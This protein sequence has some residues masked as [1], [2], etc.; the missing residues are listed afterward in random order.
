MQSY[1]PPP[2][3]ERLLLH[4]IADGVLDPHLD[5]LAQAIHARRR[6]LLHTLATQTAL[7]QLCAGDQV[8]IDNTVRPLYLRGLRGRVIEIENEWVTICVHRPVGR[9]TDGEIRCPPLTLRKLS[10]A[11]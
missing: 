4:Q 3:P 5:A 9:F 2:E 6:H 7:S 1:R 8:Q 11:A 10:K